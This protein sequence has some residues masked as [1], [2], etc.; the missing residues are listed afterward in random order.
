VRP[1]AVNGKD[2]KPKWHNLIRPWVY[3]LAAN[4]AG[5]DLRTLQC[6]PDGIVELPPL[7][8]GLALTWLGE[9]VNAWYLGMQAPLPVACKT[10]FAWFSKEDPEA[11]LIAAANEYLGG[12]N[13]PGELQQDAYLARAFPGF[14]QL[15]ENGGFEYWATRLYQPISLVWQ[16]GQS[17]A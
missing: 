3:H 12:Y 14:E 9:L 13:Y 7:S 8:S 16:Q 10:A 6:G 4:A 5:L 17:H 2:G 15:T 1:Q 11:A